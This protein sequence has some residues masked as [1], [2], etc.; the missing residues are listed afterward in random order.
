MELGFQEDYLL[1][2][3]LREGFVVSRTH[4][5]LLGSFGLLYRARLHDGRVRL[6]ETLLPATETASWA[7]VPRTGEPWRWAQVDSRATLDCDPRWTAVTITISNRLPVPL[8]AAIDAGGAGPAIRRS[9][10]P[11]EQYEVNIPLPRA[12]RE[13]RVWSETAVP[14]QLGVND[15]G[16]PLGIAV[17]E[18][19]YHA[20]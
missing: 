5:E 6:T 3:L 11:G 8:C 4:V 17:H 15:D 1:R 2:A 12:G 16:R 9:L 10:Q 20:E 18:V 13:L 7:P 14:S 19:R